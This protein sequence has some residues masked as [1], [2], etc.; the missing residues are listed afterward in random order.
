[1][2]NKLYNNCNIQ[3]KNIIYEMLKYFCNVN[4]EFYVLGISRIKK[5]F[6]TENIIQSEKIILVS[7]F[8]K[9]LNNFL[10]RYN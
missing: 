3:N 6:F 5:A 8:I 7:V 2:F 4:F 9:S 1:M 10:P